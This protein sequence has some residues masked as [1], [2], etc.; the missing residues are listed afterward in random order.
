MQHKTAD[1]P[2]DHLTANGKVSPSVQSFSFTPAQKMGQQHGGACHADT[3]KL[4]GHFH[5]NYILLSLVHML[6]ILPVIYY[7][8]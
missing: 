6:Y 2:Y 7:T 5:N 1:L 8:E 4:L 3:S